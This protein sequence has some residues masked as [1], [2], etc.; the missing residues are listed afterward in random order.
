[1][2]DG[3]SIFAW[4]YANGNGDFQFPGPELC[5]TEGDTV[6]IILNNTLPEP[7]SIMFPGIDNVQANGVPAQPTFTGGSLTSLVPAAAANNG[8]VTYSFVAGRPGTFLYESGT[9]VG[10]QVQM[11]LFGA[12]DRP[13]ARAPGL[14]LL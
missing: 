12:H 13:A 6:T 11:G 3:N 2:P 5:V 1:M 8:S 9:D 7:V 4:S 14:R 10:K